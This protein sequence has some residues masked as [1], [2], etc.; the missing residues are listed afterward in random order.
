[1][2][3]FKTFSDLSHDMV[4]NICKVPRDVDVVVGIPRSGMLVATMLALYLNKPVTD[5]DTFLSGRLSASGT[6]KP[7]RG[8]VT[9]F[10]EVQ[11]VLVVEDSVASGDSILD[12]K[13]KVESSGYSNLAYVYLAAYVSKKGRDMVDVWFDVVPQPRLFEWNYLHHQGY[14]PR[15][16]FD[17]DGVLCVDPTPEENDDGPRYREFLENAR[18]KL[19]PTS[20]VGWIVTSRLEKY[21][22]ETEGWLARQG[23]EYGKLEMMDGATAEE[24]RRLGSHAEFKAGVYKGLKDAILFIE[25]D[26]AQAQR[27]NEITH[28]AVFCPT[29]MVFYDENADMAAYRKAREAPRKVI[30]TMRELLPSGVKARI[31]RMLHM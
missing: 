18:P 5:I 13:R 14:M 6:T 1:M 24:R 27:I 17:I 15:T 19:I 8:W 10:D 23:I 20:K 25:S 26:D 7:K 21:R 22:G 16:C 29:S 12:A 2:M 4:E 3:N 30:D 31:K 28:K 9:S 11:K